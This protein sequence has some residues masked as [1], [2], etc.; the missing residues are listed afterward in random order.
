MCNTVVVT[1]TKAQ[2]SAEAKPQAPD[3]FICGNWAVKKGQI[4]CQHKSFGDER[5]IGNSNGTFGPFHV[6]KFHSHLTEE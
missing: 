5:L 2:V 6:S 3:S 1:V 4:I